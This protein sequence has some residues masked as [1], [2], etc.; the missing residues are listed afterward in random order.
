MAEERVVALREVPT[1]AQ[2][3][4]AAL[5][6]LADGIEAGEYGDVRAV[7]VVTLDTAD[8]IETL[9]YGRDGIAPNIALMFQAAIQRF[10]RAF[11]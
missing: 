11:R 9:G 4:P 2:D 10:A 1:V 7:G 3:V 8:N 6:R 5:R